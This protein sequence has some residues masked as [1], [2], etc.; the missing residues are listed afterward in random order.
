MRIC[1]FTNVRDEKHIR[2]WIVHHLLI[3]FTQIVIFD[4]KSKV[5]VKE[6]IKNMNLNN[7]KVVNAGKI[8]K[9]V[10]IRLMNLARTIAVKNNVDWMIYL[11]GDE[12]VILNTP[13]NNIRQLLNNFKYAPSLAINWLMFGSNFKKKDPDGLILEHYTKCEK[14]LNKHVKCFVQ[15]HAVSRAI[16]PHFY[17]LKPDNKYYN[18]QGK[19]IDRE[20]HFNEYNV[21]FNQAPM[22]VAHYVNQS[23][24]TYVKRRSVPR[25][26]TGELR[27]MCKLDRL[28]AEFNNVENN[29]P[30]DT[31]SERIK[32]VLLNFNYSF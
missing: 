3:G 29:Y 23:E 27:E 1:L 25:D 8:N 24:E 30:N 31:Y 7:V 4:H 14:L 15:P 21:S 22:Y 10:K 9:N 28:H 5:P 2:E 6:Q 16:N 19:T 12:F 32:K 17:V 20:F 13:Y 11:D 26:D 18:L